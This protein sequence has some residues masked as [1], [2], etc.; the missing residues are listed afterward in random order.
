MVQGLMKQEIVTT[1]I[2]RLLVM[3]DLIDVQNYD[4]IAPFFDQA[5]AAGYTEAKL[6]PRNRKPIV[7]L[8]LDNK[9]I[10]VYDSISIAA[11]ITGVT[12]TTISTC[13]K[14]KYR[15]AGGY[16]WKYLDE[17]EKHGTDT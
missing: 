12:N 9:E 6:L 10:R 2:M 3:N 14:G 16:K 7:Q 13:A 4:T 1:K 15:T 17:Y 8:S 11:R 5:Y